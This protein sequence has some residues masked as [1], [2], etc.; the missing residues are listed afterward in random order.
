MG[1]VDL[2]SG[3]RAI[4][5]LE[6]EP[7]PVGSIALVT[8]WVGVLG[9]AAH[10]SSAGLLRRRLPGQALVCTT[11]DH[12]AYALSLPETRVVGLVLETMRDAPGL[13]AGLAEAAARDIPVVALTVGSSVRGQALVDA[14]SGAIAG[15]DAGWEALFAAYGVH[16][17]FDL[18]EADRQSRDLRDRP[19]ATSGGR[20]LA[21]VHDSGAEPA[22]ELN[23]RTRM[24]PGSSSV[25]PTPTAG[26]TRQP[27]T[28]AWTGRGSAPTT[29]CSPTVAIQ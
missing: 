25:K 18:P 13:Q 3:V 26:F 7:M 11:A 22:E 27:S 9:D 23:S 16:R 15:S 6:R 20:G 19:S 17:R 28:P 8:H 14:H 29:S 10:P 5:Y 1:F 21:T 4:G 12:L 24:T 2:T